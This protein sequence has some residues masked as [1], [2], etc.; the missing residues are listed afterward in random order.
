MIL[1]P[2]RNEWR[3]I[4]STVETYIAENPLPDELTI[5]RKRMAAFNRIQRRYQEK[6]FQPIALFLEHLRTIRVLDPACGSGNFL[7]VA[8]QQLKELEKEVVAFSQSIGLPQTPF[9]SPKQFYGLEVNVFAHELASIV[10]W[11][12]FLQWNHLN[13]LSNMK[14]PILEKLDNIRLQDALLDGGE[15]AQWPE[16]EYIIGNPP[17]LGNYKMRQELGDEYAETLRRVY[18]GRVSARSDFVC[19][20][21]EKARALI[22]KGVTERAG[23]ISTNSI[24]QLANRPTL[25]RIKDTGDLFMAWSDEPLDFR[26]RGGAGEHGGL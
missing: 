10:V 7:Y 19:Y 17:F 3:G 12:G 18:S 26:G 6:T 15:E 14:T 24:S 13:G 16:A 21:F 20:W 22:A 1:E 25:E 9:V 11:I 4:R 5:D 23:L 2:L 8:F